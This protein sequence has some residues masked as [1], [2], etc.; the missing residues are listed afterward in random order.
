M[1]VCNIN[2]SNPSVLTGSLK[3]E[4]GEFP[5]PHRTTSLTYTMDN[6]QRSNSDKEGGEDQHIGLSSNH[7]EP[8][9]SMHASISSLLTGAGA[10]LGQTWFTRVVVHCASHP[11]AQHHPSLPAS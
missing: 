2:I 1:W 7:L 9:R 5:E 6:Q 11:V 8:G 10:E 3:A 4:V